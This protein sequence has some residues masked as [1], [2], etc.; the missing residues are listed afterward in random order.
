MKRLLLPILLLTSALTA[1]AQEGENSPTRDEKPIVRRVEYDIFH[2]GGGWDNIASGF[3]VRNELRYNFQRI[4]LD[5]GI[6][7]QRLGLPLMAYWFNYDEDITHHTD[8]SRCGPYPGS[9]AYGYSVLVDYNFRR[10]YVV[11]P[12]VGAGVGYG[13][14]QWHYPSCATPPAGPDNQVE[15]FALFTIRGG[16][17]IIDHLRL[18]LAVRVGHNGYCSAALTFGAVIGGGVK[19]VPEGYRYFY[20]QKPNHRTQARKFYQARSLE[21]D[22][23]SPSQLY[24][25]GSPETD[26]ELEVRRW[27][28]GMDLMAG[29]QLSSRALFTWQISE[30]LR[31]NFR[32]QP[33]NLALRFHSAMAEDTQVVRG[34]KLYHETTYKYTQN[35]LSLLTDYNFRRGHKVNPF[36]GVGVGLDVLGY[37]EWIESYHEGERESYAS[38]EWIRGGSRGGALFTVR[39]GVEFFHHMRLTAE[40]RIA[41]HGYHAILIGI[42]GHFGGGLRIKR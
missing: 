36:V 35:G 28:F 30:E 40:A 27:E 42:G 22:I 10:G 23:E 41:T 31:Y 34:E 15:R 8:H 2:I 39:G 19:N 9:P 6:E 29:C 17:E 20:G 26:Q 14:Y 12:F 37:K 16:I 25:S 7:Y 38:H 32:R 24:Y 21:P 5:I 13:Y 3:A 33:F 11:S 1:L 18:G 4:P